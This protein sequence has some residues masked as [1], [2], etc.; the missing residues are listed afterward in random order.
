MD[1]VLN[2]NDDL[3]LKFDQ[4]YSNEIQDLKERYTKDLEMVKSNLVDVYETKTEHLTQRRDELEMRNTK[5]EK[6]LA[7]RS[8][9]YEELLFEFRQL[10]KVTD[11]EIGHLRIGVRGKDDEVKRVTHLYEDNLILVKECKMENEAQRQK[12]D[13]LKTEFFKL[14]STSRE[15]SA[16]VK[17][18]L[19]VAQERLAN[20]EMI[21]K[22]L[23]AAIMNIASGSAIDD[24]GTNAVGSALINT[25]TSAPT[26]SK[27]RIQQSLLLANRL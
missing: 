8:K 5:L 13:L 14:E 10:Q 2:T 20:Y 26:S 12:L 17:A 4:Q 1:R 23:D 21:E 24:D 18:Q 25:I 9:A 19:A 15:G 22:E 3:K 7:D 6:Q 16:D 11:E 27:R